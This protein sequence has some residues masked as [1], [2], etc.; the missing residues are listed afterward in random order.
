MRTIIKWLGLGLGTGLSP[1]APGTVGSLLAVMIA[2][3][4]GIVHNPYFLLLSILIGIFICQMSEDMLGKKDDGRIVFDEFVG[5][6]IAVAGFSGYY[7]VVGFILFRVFDIL[8]P[9]P[10]RQLQKFHG[11]VGIMFDDILA[12]ALAWVIMTLVK[13]YLI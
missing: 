13:N 8:K 12:G 3:F 5:Q 6:W 2:A 9:P 1:K 10:I 11:G 7:L 4:I